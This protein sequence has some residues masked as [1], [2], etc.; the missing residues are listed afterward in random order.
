MSDST[1][2]DAGVPII[3]Q[4]R[5]EPL[6][7]T[8][9]AWLRDVAVAN[10]GVNIRSDADLLALMGEEEYFCD[11]C[12]VEFPLWPIRQWAAH[13][14]HDHNDELT[15]QQIGHIAQFLKPGLTDQIQKWLG[16][17]LV[18]RVA[19]RRRARDFGLIKWLP[20]AGDAGRGN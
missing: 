11:L 16:M 7:P 15:V 13:C 10:F 2:K 19:I 18:T 14:V 20:P 4:H 6:A 17:M 1:R 3:G 9:D 5:D 12:G 8:D